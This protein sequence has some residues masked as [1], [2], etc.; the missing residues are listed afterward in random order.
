MVG[1]GNIGKC[2]GRE[3][4]LPETAPVW[5]T[6]NSRS[7]VVMCGQKILRAMFAGGGCQLNFAC[8]KNALGRYRGKD[9]FSCALPG[10]CHVI[11]PVPV[12]WYQ[13]HARATAAGPGSVEARE[14][15]D[16][17]AGHSPG[18]LPIFRW[19][20]RHLI[21]RLETEIERGCGGWIPS[22]LSGLDFHSQDR[23]SQLAVRQG[24]AAR[25]GR[26]EDRD[27]GR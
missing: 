17:L 4:R 14:S 2:R 22:R 20:F 6:V 3:W 10:S 1:H 5:I 24:T 25:G 26:A 11:F 7:G 23:L 16:I 9:S 15:P 12:G 27:D 13:A 19:P 21:L 8:I 18:A